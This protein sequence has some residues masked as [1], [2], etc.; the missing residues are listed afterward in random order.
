MC[1][2]GGS[3]AEDHLKLMRAE[4]DLL[5]SLRFPNIVTMFGGDWATARPSARHVPLLVN[6]AHYP[7]S[8]FRSHLRK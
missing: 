1:F 7:V 8:R 6:T 3:A 4:C 2:R 5:A